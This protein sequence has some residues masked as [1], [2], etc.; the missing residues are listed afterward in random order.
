MLP[1][2]LLERA[3]NETELRQRYQPLTVKRQDS[4]MDMKT[5]ITGT[6]AGLASTLMIIFGS[7]L[8][9]AGMPLVIA[10]ALPVYV[11]ALSWGT[12]AGMAASIIT[13]IVVSTLGSPQ[14]AIMVGLIFT[15]PA[16]VAGH[17]ANLG[18]ES[19]DG[20]MQWYPLSKILFNLSIMLSLALLAAGF[21]SGIS[22]EKL[23]AAINEMA[24]QIAHSN[25]QGSQFTDTQLAEL[26]ETTY[27]LLPF[28]F[29][30]VWLVTHVLN[31][32]VGA[33]IS[34]AIGLMPRPAENIAETITL[35]KV[36]IPIMI[37]AL[38]MSVVMSGGIQQIA[39][40]IA[41]I[42]LMALALVG[43]AS[44]HVR[45]RKMPGGIGLLVFTYLM[46]VLFYFPLFLFAVVGIFRVANF[47]FNSSPNTPPDGDE[48]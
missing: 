36:I 34:R 7:R 25:P 35:P 47:Q 19:E 29:A 39:G 20:V 44:L 18:Q 30:G 17:Q 14:V 10:G 16:S 8:G 33:I 42:S 31:L 11:A 24:R 48:T 40:V 41:G 28:V 12:V 2:L 37:V 9:T 15:I 43:L 13:I 46:I 4:E 5:L 6:I 38:L 22:G 23:L 32:H 3:Q 1:K 45:A 26:A 27:R 21:I